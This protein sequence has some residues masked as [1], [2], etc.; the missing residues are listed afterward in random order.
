MV[1]GVLALLTPFVR[2]F[3]KML[4]LRYGKR[5]ATPPFE[6]Q[7]MPL[8]IR[9][10]APVEE[11]RGPEGPSIHAQWSFGYL[12]AFAWLAIRVATQDEAAEFTGEFTGGTH[13]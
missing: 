5:T 1:L 7:L 11:V 6:P 12:V 4:A 13:L 8:R 3:V 10:S 2:E 9:R